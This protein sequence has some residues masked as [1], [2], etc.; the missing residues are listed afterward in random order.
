LLSTKEFFQKYC[1]QCG[2]CVLLVV[3]FLRVIQTMCVIVAFDESA[4]INLVYLSFE[5]MAHMFWFCSIFTY[6]F[7]SSF[8]FVCVLIYKF[9]SLVYSISK[10]FLKKLCVFLLVLMNKITCLILLDL[11]VSSDAHMVFSAWLIKLICFGSIFMWVL[12]SY[13]AIPWL[14]H[15]LAMLVSFLGMRP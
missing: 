10:C 5:W 7:R 14:F 2:R 12:K 3:L 15:V 4:K 8:G 1:F 6:F 9:I 13:C 11:H